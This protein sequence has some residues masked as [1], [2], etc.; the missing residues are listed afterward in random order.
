MRL[1]ILRVIQLLQTPAYTSVTIWANWVLDTCPFAQIPT[2]SSYNKVGLWTETYLLLQAK[3]LQLTLPLKLSKRYLWLQ[4]KK[5]I[6]TVQ[7]IIRL[8]KLNNCDSGRTER[9]LKVGITRIMSSKL[10]KS[11]NVFSV[12]FYLWQRYCITVYRHPR[13]CKHFLMKDGMTL[14]K[15]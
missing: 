14:C 7:K 1:W 10:A 9:L 12:S 3:S 13:R 11:W 8:F 2:L 15:M 4:I 6:F 5:N